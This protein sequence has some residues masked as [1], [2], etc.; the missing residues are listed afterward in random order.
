MNKW[1]V[2]MST[3]IKKKL[4]NM[5]WILKMKALMMKSLHGITWMNLRDHLNNQRNNNNKLF[6]NIDQM[7][8]VK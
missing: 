2:I 1:R 4:R 5:K 8:G 6:K 7:K 3:N